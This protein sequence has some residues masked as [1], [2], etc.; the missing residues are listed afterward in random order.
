MKLGILR[1]CNGTLIIPW[2]IV[3][4][5]CSSPKSHRSWQNHIVSF[6]AK[7]YVMYSVSVK[8]RAIILCLL[9]VQLLVVEDIINTYSNVDFLFNCRQMGF[10]SNGHHMV[11]ISDSHEM[12][13]LY[14]YFYPMVTKWGFNLMVTRWFSHVGCLF[15]DHQMVFITNNHQMGFSI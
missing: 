3:N 4:S 8:D 11:F 9:L 12:G 1:Q 6:D 5:S 14:G 7:V 13:F 2:M 15:D 10:I